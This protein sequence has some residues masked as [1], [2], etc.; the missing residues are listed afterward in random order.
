MAGL[1]WLVWADLGLPLDS[2]PWLGAEKIRTRMAGRPHGQWCDPLGHT[3]LGP[4]L[5]HGDQSPSKITFRP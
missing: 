4:C 1:L 3:A 2:L 5:R